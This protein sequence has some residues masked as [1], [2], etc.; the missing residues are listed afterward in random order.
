M[1]A[2]LP[3]RKSRAQRAHNA[4]ELGRPLPRA[5]GRARGRDRVAS[6]R[7]IRAGARQSARGAG[8]RRPR[9]RLQSSRGRALPDVGADARAQAT[10]ASAR[11]KPRSVSPGRDGAQRLPDGEGED[12]R[13]GGDG[14][15][16]PPRR[17]DRRARRRA[18]DRAHHRL[19]DDGGAG[20][21]Q[22]RRHLSPPQ[23][24]QDGATSS[25]VPRSTSHAPSTTSR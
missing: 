22:P 14:G 21:G 19:G 6:P 4:E 24:F 18:D 23:G 13:V 1:P 17:G 2:T 16:R 12:G 20:A 5:L 25:R 11:R 7:A 15:T 9:E 8:R 3:R 10:A